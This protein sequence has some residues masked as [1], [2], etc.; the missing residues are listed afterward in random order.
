M[1]LQSVICVLLLT[2]AFNAQD[3]PTQVPP[4]EAK[5]HLV[6]HVDPEIPLLAK[7]AKIGGT[8]KLEV[9]I[10][11]SGDVAAVQTI[12][13]HPMLVPS[14]IDAVR[15][16]KYKP[17]EKDGKPIQ[18]ITEVELDFPKGMSD[19]ESAVLREFFPTENDCRDLINKGQYIAAETKCREAVE[20]SNRLPKEAVL[21]RYGARSLLANSIFLQERYEESIPIYEEALKLDLGYLKPDDADL[22]SNYWNLGRAY[23]MTQKFD[24]ADELYARAVSAFEAAIRSLP[25][26]KENYTQ[27][28]KRSLNEY[29]QVKEAEGQNEEAAELRK[30]A[31]SL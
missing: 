28:L 7:A 25:E 5:T 2:A 29:A 23:A 26:M 15:R 30:K 13:G 24:K 31:D 19:E 3:G 22:A 18:V 17:F 16:W 21:E 12:S 9:T 14:A 10:S 27:R 4:S 8:V 11:E 6:Q 20:I 1:P